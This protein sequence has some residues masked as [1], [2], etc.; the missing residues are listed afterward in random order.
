MPGFHLVR[1]GV[2]GHIGPFS[3][4][5]GLRHSRGSSVIVRTERGL[6]WGEVLA[7][8]AADDGP[9][10]PADGVILRRATP[11]DRLLRDRLEKHRASALERCGALIDARGVPVVL[12]DAEHLFDGSG[13]LFYFL[14]DVTDELE[15]IVQEL[16]DEYETEVA[17]HRFAETLEHGCGP[18][19]GTEAASGGC[20]SCATSCSLASACRTTPTP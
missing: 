5:D 10:Q 16:A 6:E 2:L 17:F 14:G 18:G 12:L 3:S 11:N 19:C 15:A 1:H 8:P 20:G 4:A 13:L 9:V 7:P